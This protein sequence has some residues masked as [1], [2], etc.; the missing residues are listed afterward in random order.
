MLCVFGE[1][2]VSEGWWCDVRGRGLK[3]LLYIIMYSSAVAVQGGVVAVLGG[4]VAVQGG[5]VAVRGGVVAV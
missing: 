2:R 5:V 1:G 3:V 4:T